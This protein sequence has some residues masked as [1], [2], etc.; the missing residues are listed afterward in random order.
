MSQRDGAEK[1]EASIDHW[2]PTL[3]SAPRTF[4]VMADFQPRRCGTV[5]LMNVSDFPIWSLLV[6]ILWGSLPQA[7]PTSLPTDE[8]P[9]VQST[10]VLS[11]RLPC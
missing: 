3:V 6:G 5:P 9:E 7:T 4:G 1:S 8:E 11:P 10:G 2:V